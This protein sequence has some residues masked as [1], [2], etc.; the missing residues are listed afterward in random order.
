MESTNYTSFNDW[1]ENTKMPNGKRKVLQSAIKLFSV[2]GY[3]ST[4]TAS[5]AQ[6]C[7]LSEATVFKHFK[8]K[9]DLL[10]T[11]IDPLVNSLAPSF[12]DQFVSSVK[13]QTLDINSLIEF[14]IT[15]R[16]HFIEEN[17]EVIFILMNQLLTDG[18]LRDK[19]EDIMLPKLQ[20]IIDKAD[21]LIANDDSIADDITTNE[22]LRTIS[23][24]LITSAIIEYRFPS[25]DWDTEKQIQ[26]MI[27]ITQ[28]AIRK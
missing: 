24:Q 3:N 9:K 27:K 21:K 10:K 8:S 15:N 26:S 23:S 13:G 1:L 17:H 7:G 22:F 6:A 16:F 5:I 28:R 2:N 19:L 18:E 12:G 4:S 20:Y 11:I 25:D 14:I